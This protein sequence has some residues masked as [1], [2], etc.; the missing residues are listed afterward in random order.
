MRMSSKAHR[1]LTQLFELY[2]NESWL[3]PQHVQERIATRS[4]QPSPHEDKQRIICDHM[5]GM[6]DRYALQEHQKLFD[7]MERV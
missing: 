6:T 5:A 2:V 4:A 3:L 7:P 1:V